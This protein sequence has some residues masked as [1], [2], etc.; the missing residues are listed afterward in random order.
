MN[1]YMLAGTRHQVDLQAKLGSG[2]EGVVIAH[3]RD[4]GL[5]VK[6]FHAPETG[7]Q[8]AA[9]IAAYRDRKLRAIC[10]MNLGLGPQFIL[11]QQPAFDPRGQQIV[12][13]QMR[14]V[15]AGFHKLMKLL[16]GSFRQSQ[17][18]G[19]KAI[20]ELFAG[21]FQD[22]NVIH[23]HGLV[24]GD[25]NL[26][27]LMFRDGATRAWVDTDSW[28]YPG[29][30]CLA[31]TEMFAHP[32]LFA[33]L[34]AGG[35][36]VP[37]LPHHDR[38]AFLVA[39]TMT[40][41]P[42]AHPFRMGRHPSVRGLQ[43]R[44]K[45]GIT[46]FDADVDYPAALPSP[47]VLSDDL[48]HALVIR[49]KGH[50]TDPLKAEVLQ[51][52]AA[53]V[54]ACK[55]CGTEYHASRPHC[56]ACHQRTMVSVP[57][58]IDYLLKELFKTPGTLLFAQ[59]LDT[60]LYLSCR[61][62]NQVQ[63]VRV[64]N[65]GQATI[66]TPSLPSIPGARY[67]FFK[68]GLAVCPQPNAPAPVTIEVYKLDGS[69]L[70]AVQTTTT[71]VLEGDEAVFDT[72]SRFLYRT[73]GNSLLRTEMFGNS[74]VLSD[75][76]VAEVHQQQSWF[77][78]DHSTGADREVIFGYDRALRQWEWF[79]IHGTASGSR[80]QYHKVGDLGLRTG[81][82][83]EDFA[84]YFSASSLL[85]VMK[86]IHQGR[87]YVRYAVVTFD[88]HVHQNVTM[89]EADPSFEYWDNLRGKLYQGKSVLHVTAQGI[90]KQVLADG[91]LITL[92]GTETSV[93]A[94]DQ[95]IRLDGQV[96]VVRRS[97]VLAMTKKPGS[98]P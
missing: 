65:N 75:T 34:T 9:R 94:D 1:Q 97:G 12:G 66:L 15:P 11:P 98:N 88:G 49:L 89:D 73:A 32:D 63:I 6:L 50:I 85:V 81:E 13:F 2:S 69:N 41:I 58:L 96:G 48:L 21:I 20:I 87:D 56:P 79:V 31:T 44:A 46:I 76:P 27:C 7:D 78:A 86:T 61:V 38:F 35:K 28:S 74:G 92:S 24:I 33:N 17:Q 80:Y 3:P 37:P 25:V 68:D 64:A 8:E 62:G 39:L 4:P 45:A 18:L 53:R 55:S 93:S 5:C 43:N 26:G 82:T 90:V 51:D 19:L 77:T 59:M 84:V 16:D 29:F 67:R 30:P 95:L 40:A 57:H 14:R 52:F 42:G 72:T 60:A 47:E 23:T 36:F 83:V 71:G 70:R 10:A 54:V 22:L 91:S